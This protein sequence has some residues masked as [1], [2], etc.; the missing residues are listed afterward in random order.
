M[1]HARTVQDLIDNTTERTEIIAVLDGGVWAN[2]PIPF[3]SRVN[4]IYSPVTLGQRAATNL[5]VRLSKAKY[6]AKADAHCS[7]DKDFDVK[8]LEA[9]EKAGDNTIIVPI[10][11]NLHAFSW[12]CYSCGFKKYQGPT[13]NGCEKCGSTKVR[14]KM[15]WQPRRG[16]YST[17]YSF[18]SQPHFDYNP[19]LKMSELYKNG[20]IVGYGLFLDPGL[21]SSVVSLLADLADTHKLARGKYHFWG[22]QD[23][24]SDAMGLLAI[25]QGR[26]VGSDKVFS[27]RNELEMS[28]VATPPVLTKMVEDGDALPSTPG[29]FVDK[30]SIKNT[31]SQL[32]FSEFGAP[33]ITP[34]INPAN[35]IP[36]PRSIINSD[37]IQKFNNI[38][39]GQFVYNEKTSSFHNGSVSLKPLYDKSLTETMSLQGSFFMSTREKYWELNLS[40]ESVGSWGNQGIELACKMWLSG[41]R[42]LVNHKTWYAHMF[43]TQG[44]DFSFPYEQSGRAVEK[45]KKKVWEHFFGGRFKQQ[46]HPVSW[47]VERFWPVVKDR[48][49]IGWTPEAL[50]ALKEREKMI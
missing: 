49:G 41:G 29:Q 46:I 48:N 34:L 6:V 15:V 18:D 22:G 40:D 12:K 37:L 27:V 14:R 2:P 36:T 25:N 9:F 4:V 19:N 38:L 20:T 42:V 45:A 1:F 23:M 28:G 35:P 26:S 11:R 50:Q 31:M 21:S 24:S 13:P 30:P 33:T 10:M 7:F 16:T 32:F 43:R 8:M 17:S 5:G 3:H 44:G 47:L 39:G